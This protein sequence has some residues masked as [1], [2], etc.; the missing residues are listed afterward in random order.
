MRIP[1]AIPALFLFCA[2]APAA[3]AMIGSAGTPSGLEEIWNR[4]AQLAGGTGTYLGKS[5]DG[6]RWMLTAN[7]VKDNS[8]VIATTNGGGIALSYAGTAR[9][10][11]NPDGSDADLRLVAVS[12]SG[13]GAAYLD[14]LGD[15]GVFSETLPRNTPLYAVGT[16]CAL[17][18][19]KSYATGTRRKQAAEFFRD[20]STTLG[21]GNA[22]GAEVFSARG[23]SFQAGLYDSGSGVF[24]RDAAGT[25]RLAGVVL[26]VGGTSDAD[27]RTSN[28]VG[29]FENAS[30]ENPLTCVTYFAD[31][32]RYAAQI[33]E[34]LG[35]GAPSAVPE[36]SALG[37]LAGAF[38]LACAAARRRRE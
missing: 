34:T 2:A 4:T 28:E 19:G 23:K 22:V 16:G 32:S 6:T 36:P 7:H 27:G 5:A 21:N 15:I 8:G 38:A 3:S 26:A 10:L 35:N 9:V 31:I 17:E 37:L 20:F 12:V 1:R 24:A 33:D 29:F 25:W 18:I 13:E 11:K 14:A 30:G